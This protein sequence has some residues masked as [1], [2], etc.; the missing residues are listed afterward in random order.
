VVWVVTV[1]ASVACGSAEVGGVG[2]VHNGTGG[3]TSGTGGTSATSGGDAGQSGSGGATGVGGA[4]PGGTAGAS[5]GSGG[6]DVPD[7]GDMGTGGGGVGPD[8]GWGGGDGGDAPVVCVRTVQAASSAD[9]AQAIMRAM[10]GDC[11][12]LADGTYTFPTIGVKGTE[13]QPIV[14]RAANTLKATVATGDLVLQGAAFVTVQGLMWSGAGTIHLNDCDHCRLS[15]TRIQRNDSGGGEWVTVNGTSKYA[16]ID[17]ND[18]GPQTHLGNMIQL[19]GSGPQIVQYTRIDHNFFHDVQYSG[20]NGWECI[21]AGLSGWS[22]SSAFTVIEQNFFLRANNDPETI[23]VKSTDNILRHNTMRATAGQFSLRHGHRTSVYGNYILGDGVAAA[24]GIRAFDSDH[25]IYNNYIQGTSFG[26][27]LEGGEH[28]DDAGALT[29]HKQVFRVTVAFNTLV[30]AH[31]IA[32]GGSHPLEPVDCTV[33]YNILQGSGTLLSEAAGTTNTTYLGNILN[34]G[35]TGIK[36]GVIMADPKL[37]KVGDVF[38]IGAGSPAIDAAT[39]PFPF[40]TDDIDGKPRM[41]PDIG[42]DEISTAPALYGLLSEADVGP[43]S[44]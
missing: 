8:A 43:M 10:P 7:A 27:L 42:A 14:I 44:P 19:A 29:D 37:V 26:V 17:H 9:L 31:G 3:A 1:C 34:G 18:F 20:G 15:R 41:A 35:T 5:S 22:F 6:S 12:V 40:V 16:R 23:S 25:Q 21:R 2:G 11:I 36:T 30:D 32:L 39:M 4:G 33:A 28:D 38:K 24:G 13:A